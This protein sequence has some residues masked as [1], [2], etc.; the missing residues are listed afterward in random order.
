MS[1]LYIKEMSVEDERLSKIKREMEADQE[2]LRA[3]KNASKDPVIQRI[4]KII[5]RPSESN[6]HQRWNFDLSNKTAI[7]EG[8]KQVVE[9]E[10]RMRLEAMG[11]DALPNSNQTSTRKSEIEGNSEDR[12]ESSGSIFGV[13]TFKSYI[14]WYHLK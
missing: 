4:N 2:R 1:E 12:E 6:V 14:E 10:K 9:N 13:S 5:N 7:Y 8:I 11:E 3:M